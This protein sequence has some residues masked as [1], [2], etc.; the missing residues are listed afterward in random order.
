[1]S[2]FLL[3]SFTPCESGCQT[4][5]KQDA[6]ILSRFKNAGTKVEVR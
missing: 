6:L 1:M 2:A 4:T 5:A 3:H